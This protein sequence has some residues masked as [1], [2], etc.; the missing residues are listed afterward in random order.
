MDVAQRDKTA[1]SLLQLGWLAFG[2]SVA[3]ESPCLSW[4]SEYI[5]FHHGETEE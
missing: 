4:M 3:E 2:G 1:E 5:L